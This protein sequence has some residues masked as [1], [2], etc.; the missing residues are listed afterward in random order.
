[1]DNMSVKKGGRLRRPEFP[2]V[3]CARSGVIKNFV[4]G[5]PAAPRLDGIGV[6]SASAQRWAYS[7]DAL[8]NG[9][10]P[11]C[12]MRFTAQGSSSR[13]RK[14]LRV[15][16]LFALLLHGGARPIRVNEEVTS[17]LGG[18]AGGRGGDSDCICKAVQGYLQL[19]FILP[20]PLG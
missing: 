12:C 3:I 2:R 8:V 19:H 1:M 7:F 11:R 14:L 10:M 15:L 20:P 4:V 16:V 18:E 5:R 9:T 13:S 6:A 17:C